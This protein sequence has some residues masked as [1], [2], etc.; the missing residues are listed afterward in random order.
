MYDNNSPTYDRMFAFKDFS[1]QNS[2]QQV[3]NYHSSLTLSNPNSLTATDNEN[4]GFICEVVMAGMVADANVACLDT[5][6]PGSYWLPTFAMITNSNDWQLLARADGAWI[7]YNQTTDQ[8]TIK[9][10]IYSYDKDTQSI[11]DTR[12]PPE[13]FMGNQDTQVT[14]VGTTGLLACHGMVVIQPGITIPPIKLYY[15]DSQ[16]NLGWQSLDVSNTAL[17]SCGFSLA[18]TP[19]HILHRVNSSGT[20]WFFDNAPNSGEKKLQP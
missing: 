16:N 7:S 14:Q 3:P 18:G 6:K 8:D 13:D 10:I 2:W 20:L 11:V 17:T 19:S 1:T 9:T 12:F 5:N 15:Y 4:N